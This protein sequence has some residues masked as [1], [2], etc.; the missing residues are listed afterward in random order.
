MIISLISIISFLG[1]TVE[2]MPQENEASVKAWG[3]VDDL[4]DEKLELTDDQKEKII[5]RKNQFG[6]VMPTGV[7]V[8][9]ANTAEDLNNYFDEGMIK[10]KVSSTKMNAESNVNTENSWK[11]LIILS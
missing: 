10:R 3:Q 1:C 2:E 4:L 6:T 7:N 9:V 5:I 8:R 11:Y